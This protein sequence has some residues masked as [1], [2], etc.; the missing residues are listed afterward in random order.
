MLVFLQ[1]QIDRLRKLGPAYGTISK[2]PVQMD[3]PFRVCP[4]NAGPRQGAHGVA[5]GAAQRC[6]CMFNPPAGPKR[7]AVTAPYIGDP[8]QIS[9]PAPKEPPRG[10]RTQSPRPSPEVPR[11]PRRIFPLNLFSTVSRPLGPRGF[12][13]FIKLSPPSMVPGRLNPSKSQRHV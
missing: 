4:A 11:S 13:P 3:S 8:G 7:L 6:Q 5:Y 10:C 9:T 2:P 12:L 1:R